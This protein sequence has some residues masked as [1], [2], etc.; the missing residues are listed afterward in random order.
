M[1]RRHLN[2]DE[3][4]NNFIDAE[5]LVYFKE[6]LV[7]TKP[8]FAATLKEYEDG[9]LLFELMQQKI[10]NKSSDTIALK[11]YFDTHQE[12]YKQKELDKIKGKVMNDFQNY[13]EKD[14]I[15]ELRSSNAVEVNKKVLKKL[16]KYYR[17][18]S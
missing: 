8:E 1:N 2:T 3:L 7:N 6:N 5:V 13:L 18:E 12:N 14:W 17:K 15:D 10:W 9:L 4:L 16:I 11:T